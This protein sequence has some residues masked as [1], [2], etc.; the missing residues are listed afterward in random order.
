MCVVW[1]RLASGK[2]RCVVWGLASGKCIVGL[3]EV[4]SPAVC[5]V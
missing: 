4:P 5:A 3:R 1:G 2:C